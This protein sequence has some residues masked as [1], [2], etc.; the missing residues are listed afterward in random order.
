VAAVKLQLR[1]LIPPDLAAEKGERDREH[2]LRDELAIDPGYNWRARL[3]ENYAKEGRRYFDVHDED[4]LAEGWHGRQP[5]AELCSRLDASDVDIA[6]H[7][8]AMGL[9]IDFREVAD[10]LGVLPGGTLDVRLRLT[11]DRTNA[12]TRAELAAAYFQPR[13]L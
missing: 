3:Q 10:R 4:V 13:N 1:Q 2:W 6:K 12:S 7:L 8:V 9:A 11:A 5:L